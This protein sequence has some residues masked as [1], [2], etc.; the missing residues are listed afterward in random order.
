MTRPGRRQQG[1]AVI[2]ALLMLPLMALLLWAMA[3]IG[4]LQFSAQQ[5]TQASR[6]AAMSGSLGQPLQALRAPAAMA[7]SSDAIA[8]TGVAS[9]RISALQ[10]EWFGAGLRMLSVEVR[11]QPRAGDPSAWLPIARRISVASGAG[12]A[13]GD[14]DAQRRIGAARTGWRQAGDGSLSEATRMQRPVDRVDGPWG[15]PKL[16]LDWL[17]TWADVVPADRLSN[18]REQSR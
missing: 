6:K 1:Q 5:T 2:E 10:D 15:R 12:H 4:S 7:L 3:G 17:S 9:P 8:L 14:A 18:R 13:N 11:T 16:S